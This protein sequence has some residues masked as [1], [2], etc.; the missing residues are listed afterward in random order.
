MTLEDQLLV[1]SQNN[2]PAVSS[3]EAPFAQLRTPTEILS[4]RIPMG[5]RNRTSYPE[6]KLPKES[7]SPIDTPYSDNRQELG[8][9]PRR[10]SQG[11][12]VVLFNNSKKEIPQTLCAEILKSKCPAIVK[13]DWDCV[14]ADLYAYDLII[15]CSDNIDAALHRI[16]DIARRRARANHA[17]SPS[18]LVVS[19]TDRY[20]LAR[21]EI[22]FRRGAHF[23]HLHDVPARFRSELEQIRLC[24]RDIER[25]SPPW[26]IEY[27]GNGRT[28]HVIVSF[29]SRRGLQ[30]VRAADSHAA[31]LAVF[32]M[33][34]HIHRSITAWRKLLLGNSLFRPRGG[35]FPVPSRKSLK[36]HVHRDFVR[37]LQRAYDEAKTAF[38][39]ERTIERIGLGDRTVGYRIRGKWE[40][41]RRL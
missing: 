41:V 18:Y 29:V 23:L 4:R 12:R 35:A 2:G 38:S 34:N 24:R 27:E 22:E 16:D 5:L 31:E 19:A 8:H 32:I 21:F 20:P 28:L 37:D 30:V 25:S 9:Y 17:I 3:G 15:D 13:R 10:R 33:H 26:L 6:S 36:I 11:L 39:A 1:R 40:A 14:V 7:E